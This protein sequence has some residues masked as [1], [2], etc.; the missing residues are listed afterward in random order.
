AITADDIFAGSN[1]TA[2]NPST[3][4]WKTSSA[5]AKSDLN[6]VYVHISKDAAG[7][8]WITASADRLSNNGTAF[9]DFELSQAEI[10]QITDVGCSSPPCG[11]FATNPA[12]AVAGDPLFASGGRTVNDMLVTA[13]YGHGGGGVT[14]G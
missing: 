4:T 1:K 14:F 13:G 12:G 11:H 10:N 9:A 7:D 5:A 6:N 3:Y 2:D 8:S